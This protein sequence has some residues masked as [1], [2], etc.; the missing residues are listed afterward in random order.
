[1]HDTPDPHT[2]EKPLRIAYLINQYPKVSHSFIRREILALE[3]RGVVVERYA[4]RGWVDEVADPADETER[5]RTRFIL[6]EGP[7]GVGRALL[8]ELLAH[9]KRL[10]SALRE[11]LRLAKGGERSLIYHLIYLGEAAVLARWL[12]ASGAQHLHAH[13]GTNSTNVA[14]LAHQL[15]GPGYSFTVHGPEEFDKPVAIALPRKIERSRF[16]VGVSAFGRSQLY[17]WMAPGL[18]PK[19]RV[20]HCGLERAFHE[21]HEGAAASAAPLH[22]FVCVGRLCEQKG[23]VL[24][25]EALGLL[26]ARGLAPSVVFA[27]DG[28]MRVDVEQRAAALGVTLQVRITGW[29]G[30]KQ[31]RDELLNARAMLLPSFAEGLPVAI[32]EA[33]ALRRAVI[34]T[35]V[36]GIPE[37]VLPG[38]T[39]WLVPPSD[40]EALADAMAECLAMHPEQRALMGE[41]AS[42]RVLE[43]HDIDQESAKLA[44]YIREAIAV[45][46]HIRP[47]LAGAIT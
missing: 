43:R 14:L 7:V 22:D 39:G 29:I 40:A 11:T 24:I 47:V 37:L 5:E 1:M 9:P 42:A 23:Q 46:R 26:K 10:L 36:A 16:V 19:V 6:K 27:G 34:S 38:T 33:M 21:G 25:I 35:Y 13:F 18:W 17:R 41:A 8:G 45:D 2:P 28:P 3:A 12:R 4:L 44:A 15:G 20:V 32:M 31:V 30:S